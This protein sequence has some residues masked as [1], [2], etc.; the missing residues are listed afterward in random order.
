MPSEGAKKWFDK[1]AAAKLERK[2]ISE[3][4]ELQVLRSNYRERPYPITAPLPSVGGP[5]NSPHERP[6]MSVPQMLRLQALKRD[7]EYMPL[8]EKGL[9]HDEA[10]KKVFPEAYEY[11]RQREAEQEKAANAIESAKN[12]KDIEVEDGLEVVLA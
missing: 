11:R 2:N 10:E 1:K 9:S 7:H 8:R 5:N 3:R 6:Y 4:H 12:L